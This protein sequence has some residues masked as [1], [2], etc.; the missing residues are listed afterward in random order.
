MTTNGPVAPSYTPPT[1]EHCHRRLYVVP[2]TGLKKCGRCQCMYS[3]MGH[4]IHAS[5]QCFMAGIT[6]PSEVV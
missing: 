4:F 6:T 1:C 5:H 2:Q 3:S